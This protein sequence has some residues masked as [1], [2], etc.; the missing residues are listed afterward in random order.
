MKKEDIKTDVE[1]ILL[2]LDNCQDVSLAIYLL[3]KLILKLQE[4]E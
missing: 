4:D 2:T 3:K 1:E